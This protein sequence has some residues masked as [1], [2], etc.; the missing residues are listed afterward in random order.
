MCGLNYVASISHILD[1]NLDWFP[2]P[3]RLNKP[4]FWRIIRNLYNRS[5]RDDDDCLLGLDG[6]NDNR[7]QGLPKGVQHGYFS[8]LLD[9]STLAH[10]S[11]RVNMRDCGLLRRLACADERYRACDGKALDPFVRLDE[12]KKGRL[13]VL[14]FAAPKRT[15]PRRKRPACSFFAYLIVPNQ[16]KPFQDRKRALIF[17]NLTEYT[18]PKRSAA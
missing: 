13:K 16:G 15:G 18:C 7:T 8:S 17:K 1:E 9:I 12:N 14:R 5:I 3:D 10:P 2:F 11:W 6:W 4:A